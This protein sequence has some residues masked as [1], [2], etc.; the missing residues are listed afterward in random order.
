[1]RVL[2]D[3]SL[4]PETLSKVR[5][6]IE[7][8][9]AVSQIRGLVGRNAG[10]FRFIQATIVLRIDDLAKAHAVSERIESAI[11]KELSHV[12]RVVIH[13]E[14][15]KRTHLRV[16]IPVMEDRQT[17]SHHFGESPYFLLCT[18]HLANMSIADRNM[19]EN[20]YASVDKAKGIKAAE[21]LTGLKIDAVLLP[22]DA[23]RKA[24]AYVF[25]DAG[26]EMYKI[27]SRTIVASIH[28][29]FANSA[30]PNLFQK[31]R[32]HDCRTAGDRENNK[33][34]AVSRRQIRK[35]ADGLFEDHTDD[36][37]TKE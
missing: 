28:E 33:G 17:V 26:I 1:M 13:Y 31:Q 9:P 29:A 2:L 14:P 21:W 16:A 30:P 10:R 7:A 5:Q 15:Q 37:G 12:E 35:G 6:L 24:P 27:E 25:G 32:E 22:G 11:K 18:V 23:K 8:E 19:V 20:P 36:R 34:P 4:D 3:A